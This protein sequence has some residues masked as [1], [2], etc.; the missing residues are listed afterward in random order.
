MIKK[1]ILVA[2]SGQ[3]QKSGDHEAQD[4]YQGDLFRK[5]RAYAELATPLD[6]GLW[7][8]MSARFGIIHPHDVYPVYDRRL[9]ETPADVYGA[10]LLSTFQNLIEKAREWRGRLVAPAELVFLAG[11]EYREAFS[12]YILPLYPQFTTVST[13]LHGLGIG[14]PSL[15][16]LARQGQRGPLFSFREGNHAKGT[17]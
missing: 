8:I 6:S 7:L 5:S 4:L 2:C 9:G 10:Q 1:I 17:R 3:K 14:Q 11:K 12:R 16:L 13:P 15:V